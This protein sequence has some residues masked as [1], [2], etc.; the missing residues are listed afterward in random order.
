EEAVGNG[1]AVGVAANPG[2]HTVAV[3]QLLLASFGL[4]DTVRAGRVH[5]RAEG[6]GPGDHNRLRRR[7]RRANPTRG[8]EPDKEQLASHRQSSWTRRESRIT[9]AIVPGAGG[10]STPASS[11]GGRIRGVRPSGLKARLLTGAVWPGPK[12]AVTVSARRRE[13]LLAAP[14]RRG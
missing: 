6:L 9:S 8:G 13:P 4:I 10:L 12:K 7:L 1:P 14:D 11:P 2:E 5:Q 3:A